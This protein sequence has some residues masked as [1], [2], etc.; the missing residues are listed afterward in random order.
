MKALTYDV[1]IQVAARTNIAKVC[2]IVVHQ[3][4]RFALC[5]RSHKSGLQAQQYFRDM[6]AAGVAP[7]AD[8]FDDLIYSPDRR[9]TYEKGLHYYME[10]IRMKVRPMHMCRNGSA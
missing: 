1:A 10:M 4:R 5:A 9:L 3:V 7:T 8:T 6:L 2:M